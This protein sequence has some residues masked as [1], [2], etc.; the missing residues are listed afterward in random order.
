VLLLTIFA[1]CEASGG[2]EAPKMMESDLD[3]T[4]KEG[5]SVKQRRMGIPAIDAVIPVRTETATFSL[6]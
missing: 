3:Q 4:V 5:T 1:G 2:R 6:G